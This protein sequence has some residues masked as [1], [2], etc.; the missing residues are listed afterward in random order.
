M[1][2]VDHGVIAGHEWHTHSYRDQPVHTHSHPEDSPNHRHDDCVLL[3]ENGSASRLVVGSADGPRLAGE[4]VPMELMLAVLLD[5]P[6]DGELAS[7]RARL[8][9]MLSRLDRTVV[10]PPPCSCSCGGVHVA[11]CC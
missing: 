7:A 1:S 9:E 11:A 10:A 3:W 4:V 6:T 8:D 2:N 5:P